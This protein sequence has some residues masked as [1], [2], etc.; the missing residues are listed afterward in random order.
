MERDEVTAK[1]EE[2]ETE[3]TEVASLI[4]PLPDNVIPSDEFLRRTRMRLLK[5]ESKPQSSGQA[6]A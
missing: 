3:L 6:A 2:K 4:R 5:L 1:R